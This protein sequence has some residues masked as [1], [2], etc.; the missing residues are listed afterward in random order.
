MPPAPVITPETDFTG[1]L[2]RAVRESRGV[3][4]REIS[5]TTKIGKPFLQAIEEDDFGALPAQVYVR[6][7]VAELAKFL[8]LDPDH[9]SRTYIR[10]YR[11]WLTER[12]KL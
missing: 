11:R 12:G 5:R 4:L 9:V 10:R 2:L 6:G 8:E 1:G 3:K 7:F